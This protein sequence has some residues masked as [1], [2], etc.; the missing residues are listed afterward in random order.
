ML[1]IKKVLNC[2]IIILLTFIFSTIVYADNYSCTDLCNTNSNLI[3][4]NLDNK[5]ASLQDFENLRSISLNERLDGFERNITLN[6]ENIDR[7]LV[8]LQIVLGAF[9]LALGIAVYLG[10][11]N[12][13]EMQKRYEENT[14]AR[15]E[16]IAKK[17]DLNLNAKF[18]DLTRLNN[19][20]FSAPL[21]N[22]E[23]KLAVIEDRLS[24]PKH[25]I[26]F[27]Q[28]AIAEG[29]TSLETFSEEKE[30]KENAFD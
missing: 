11:A 12:I 14:N 21:K 8:I 30:E 19:V 10:Y 25:E 13:I 5:I 29:R 15:L 28:K 26:Q 9:A 7:L 1:M 27:L 6:I 3:K 17:L 2:T 23:I 18:D 22:V 20:A 24:N 16:N 4:E